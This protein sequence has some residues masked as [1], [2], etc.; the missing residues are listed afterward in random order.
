MWSTHAN[1]KKKTLFGP[2]PQP[3]SCKL[4]QKQK[5]VFSPCG[6]LPHVPMKR[7]GLDLD[8]L[9]NYQTDTHDPTKI[10][11]KQGGVSHYGLAIYIKKY[12]K[13]KRRIMKT[14]IFHH[15]RI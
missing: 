10:E 6:S 13:A 3:S 1:G 2:P 9:H 8:L 7:I 15:T 5:F 12:L 4:N 11:K 14:Q